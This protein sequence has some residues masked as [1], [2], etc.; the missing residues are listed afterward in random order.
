MYVFHSQDDQTTIFTFS[1]HT[2]QNAN[3][4]YLFAPVIAFL[5]IVERPMDGF[6]CI[7]LSSLRHRSLDPVIHKIPK[8]SSF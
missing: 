3:L 1:G 7:S 8:I 4:S 6:V 5:S 2:M